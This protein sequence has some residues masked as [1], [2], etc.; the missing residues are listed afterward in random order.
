[1]PKPG[2]SPIYR[3]EIR[4]SVTTTIRAIAVKPGFKDSKIMTQ[5]WTKQFVAS[6]LEI[7]DQNG[8]AIPDGV[9]SGAATA[10]RI[11]LITTQ[12]NLGSASTNAA[13]KVSGDS[14]EV[15]LANAGSLGDAFEFVSQPSLKHPFAKTRRQ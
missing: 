11:K 2:I 15:V 3:D 12:D 1:M 9:I 5:T 14:E 7:L 8:N 4:V 6:R 13:T 10:V